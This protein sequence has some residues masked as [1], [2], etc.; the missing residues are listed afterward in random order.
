ML[1]HGGDIEGYIEEYGN[2][3]IDFSANVNPF[4]VPNAVK[5]AIIEAIDS[6]DLYPDPLSRKLTC[7][8]AE[9]EAVP[10]ERII[11][12]NGAA[13]LIFRLALAKMPKRALITAPTFAEYEQALA[14][15]D[16]EIV[17]H[18]LQVENNYNLTRDLLL[19]LNSDIDIVFL[20]NPNNPTGKTIDPDILCEITDACK[21]KNITLVVDE[22]FNEFLDCGAEHSLK[23]RLDDCSNLFILKAF[24]K[25]YG[26]AGVRLGYGFCNNVEL[27]A[28]MRKVGQP[29]AVSNL[30]QAAG[31]A[32]VN[33]K[34]YT[35][36]TLA[37][38]RC[39]RKY[40]CEKL[41]EC[42]Q[43]VIGSEANYIFFKSEIQDL[44]LKLKARGILIRSCANYDGLGETY[45]RI[46][47]KQH[48]DNKKLIAELECL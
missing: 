34:D 6:A 40:L 29:W 8:I 21:A 2:T 14:A 43:H 32:A 9:S 17:K 27:L 45:Y 5:K 26:M 28:K 31:I 7:A 23:S 13:D 16:C 37:D 15:V 18:Y 48:C 46:G 38:M 35:K 47:V 44:D 24:T 39:E 33:S 36:K 4:G 3:P 12:G 10:A 20:C 30:A 1:I 25:L 19:Q 41:L 22:C 42:K 11:C